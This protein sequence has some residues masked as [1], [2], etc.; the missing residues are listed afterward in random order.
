MLKL[1][2]RLA[3]RYHDMVDLKVLVC[4]GF[5]EVNEGGWSLVRDRG[6]SVSTSQKLLKVPTEPSVFWL[7]NGTFRRSLPAIARLVARANG[8]K[9]VMPT[10][11]D[12][13]VLY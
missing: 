9:N 8:R 3:E 2:Y 4:H 13:G 5:Q 12:E 11:A 6:L 1:Q 10:D 7:Q